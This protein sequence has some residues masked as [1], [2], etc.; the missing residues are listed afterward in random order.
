MELTVFDLVLLECLHQSDYERCEL[1]TLYC[2]GKLQWTVESVNHPQRMQVALQSVFPA[3][4][5][6]AAP[7]QLGFLSGGESIGELVIA[8]AQNKAEVPTC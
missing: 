6:L 1:G 3:R 5:S 7:A 4:P 8:L 2:P